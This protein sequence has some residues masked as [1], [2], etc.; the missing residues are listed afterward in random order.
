VLPAAATQSKDQQ[1]EQEYRNQ[2]LHQGMIQTRG[3]AS[4]GSAQGRCDQRP[5]RPSPARAG[6]AVPHPSMRSV[7][8]LAMVSSLDG[9][10][11]RMP[12][13]PYNL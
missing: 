13:E 12:A 7:L 10:P 9:T 5:V 3:P 6:T 4:P 1:K 11:S 8:T 2:A